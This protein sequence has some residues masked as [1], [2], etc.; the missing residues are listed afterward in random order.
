MRLRRAVP[1]S[2]RPAIP[3]S[4]YRQQLRLEEVFH[5]IS[6]MKFTY[7]PGEGMTEIYLSLS[8]DTGHA[9][10]TFFQVKKRVL[11]QIH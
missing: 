7:E 11:Y 1:Q 4:L 3:A 6:H 9:G 10:M 2:H 8:K 5:S